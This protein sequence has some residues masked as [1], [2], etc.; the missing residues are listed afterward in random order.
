MKEI[1]KIF[2]SILVVLFLIFSGMF[3]MNSI[4][5]TQIN[6]HNMRADFANLVNR[7]AEE[8]LPA[9]VT[10]DVRNGIGS[11]VIFHEEKT[12]HEFYGKVS[13]YYVL[14]NHHVIED[15]IKDGI[16][17]IETANQRSF[18]SEIIAYDEKKDLAVIYFVYYSN[19][20][21]VAKL[22]ETSPSIGEVLVLIGNPKGQ[23]N[24]VT[25]GNFKNITILGN[26]DIALAHN[27][28]GSP[29]MSGG[30]VFNTNLEIVG[31]HYRGMRGYNRSG[32]M[33]RS[34]YND[35]FAIPV[36]TVKK[37]LTEVKFNLVFKGVLPSEELEENYISD[38]R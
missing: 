12:T 28:P 36:E 32:E 27:T 35:G 37:F 6:S 22:A 13:Y 38:L 23:K 1:K 7:V 15:S 4:I 26:G 33:I 8:A 14:T 34:D 30:G 10:V 18:Q 2:N 5:A 21:K 16:L 9:S 20:F 25:F 31:I 24:T 19:K 29:G 17:M 11:G 3:L